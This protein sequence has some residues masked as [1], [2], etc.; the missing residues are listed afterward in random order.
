MTPGLFRQVLR[1]LRLADIDLDEARALILLRG[2]GS[3]LRMAF[4]NDHPWVLPRKCFSES[5]PN[6]SAR[7]RHN[8]SFDRFEIGLLTAYR[9]V[10][11]SGNMNI[12]QE[13][14]DAVDRI[15]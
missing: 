9:C 14:A 1:L 2:G 7:A 10:G 3:K 6:A 11:R 8:G 4:W 5:E 12:R 13:A 15:D